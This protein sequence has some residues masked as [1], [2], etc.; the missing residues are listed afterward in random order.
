MK[1]FRKNFDSYN[2]KINDAYEE[3]DHNKS[4]KKWRKIFGDKFGQLKESNTDNSSGTATVAATGLTV[5]KSVPARKP[6]GVRNQID[7]E[8]S[9]R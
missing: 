4:V 5:G 1:N 6:Y 2:D 8:S 9:P 3:E 7:R